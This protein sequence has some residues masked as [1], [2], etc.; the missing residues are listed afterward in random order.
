MSRGLHLGQP[1]N[2]SGDG[3]SSVLLE[4]LL[5]LRSRHA[6]RLSE[7]IKRFPALIDGLAH[8]DHNRRESRAAGLGLDT[9]RG[10]RRG[11]TQHVALGETDL[12]PSRS[13]ALR[14]ARNLALGRREIVTQ[15][16]DR[17]TDVREL[18]LRSA[19]DVRESSQRGRRFLRRHVRGG[20]QRH[21]RLSETFDVRDLDTKLTGSLRHPSNLRMR[22]RHLARHRPDR[23][24]QGIDLLRRTINRFLDASECRFI[25]DRGLGHATKSQSPGSPDAE[26]RLPDLVPLFPLELHRLGHATHAG[27]GN[28]PGLVAL[29]DQLV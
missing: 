25:I 19:H 13:E 9:H 28:F 7:N 14:H 15:R 21:H 16:D 5:E 18:G 3:T 12:V 24:I 22:C 27:L 23:R 10:E 1:L 4:R 2:K 26:H 17:R 11:N 6:R 20:T 29:L 8:L